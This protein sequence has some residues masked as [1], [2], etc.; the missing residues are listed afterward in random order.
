MKS[1]LQLIR[2]VLDDFQRLMPDAKGLDRDFITIEHRAEHEGST[3]LCATL[4]LLCDALDRGLADGRFACPTNFKKVRGGALPRL[5]SG[6]LCKVFSL[7][8]SMLKEPSPEAIKSIRELTRLLKKLSLPD[9]QAEKL[10]IKAK[11]NFIKDDA[12]CATS[13]TAYDDR[14]LRILETVSRQVLLHLDCFQPS[15]ILCKHG[16]GAVAE[17][18][19]ANKKWAALCDHSELLEEHGL[20]CLYISMYGLNQSKQSISMATGG[21]AECRLVSVP[22][23]S[24]SRRTITIEPVAYQFVQQ[25]Y[26]NLL[27]TH[28]K[29]CDVLSKCLTLDDQSA[30][31]LLAD[32]GSQTGYWATLDLKSASDLLSLSLVKF[33]FANRPKFLDG[34]LQCRSSICET[35]V[36]ETP[37]LRLRKYAGMGNATTFPIQ[38]V[39]FAL[40]AIC[41][42]LD[43]GR[44]ITRRRILEVAS[45]V[46][47]YGDD[48]IVPSTFA[49]S[50]V[51]WI[52]SFGLRVNRQKSFWTGQFR[53]S[54][55][56][57][58]YAGVD[59]TP[60]YLKVLPS[61]ATCN[62]GASELAS[63]VSTSNSLWERCLYKASECLRYYV[64]DALGRLPLVRKDSGSLGWVTRQDATTIQFWNSRLHRF[65]YSGISVR[66]TYRKDRLSGYPA[67]LKFFFAPRSESQTD[68]FNRDIKH[69]ERSPRRFQTRIARSRM[70][71]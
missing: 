40:I 3:F 46:R 11:L 63:L 32:C 51:K 45:R 35:G 28:I 47:V 66:P 17:G 39:V 69:L 61:T 24:T 21:K 27:R 34:I 44:R 5:F 7:D 50:T 15:D 70:P 49:E 55:G 31:R 43:D 54:C 60:V 25:G 20:D 23:N 42:Q 71:S 57:D 52:E 12:S 68:L 13:F 30:N 48:I 18:L 33:I 9:E 14:L 38:S 29:D 6:L 65:E 36:E 62:I 58:S 1:L 59:V 67:L 37:L 10:D 19:S 64:E 22:K 26:N 4:P 16:P 2:A 41:A 8:G 56:L 53:E